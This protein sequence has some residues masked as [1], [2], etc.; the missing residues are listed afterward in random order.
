MK[1]AI[2]RIKSRIDRYLEM[3]S[4]SKQA[5]EF[6]RMMVIIEQMMRSR[7]NDASV[8]KAVDRIIEAEGQFDG[9]NCY[10]VLWVNTFDSPTIIGIKGCGALRP[11]S[12]KCREVGEGSETGHKC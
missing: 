11:C 9:R 12:R 1:E 7:D 3:A 5:E 10:P 4:S 6:E 8:E 2:G